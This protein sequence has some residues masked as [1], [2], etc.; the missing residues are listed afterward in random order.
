MCRAAF[1]AMLTD[2]SVAASAA[3]SVHE[4]LSRVGVVKRELRSIVATL[5]SVQ[6]DAVALQMQADAAYA[7]ICKVNPR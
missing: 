4:A 1:S 2:A 5:A 6:D 7:L 3:R